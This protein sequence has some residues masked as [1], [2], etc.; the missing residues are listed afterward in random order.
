MLRKIE[1]PKQYLSSR[2]DGPY[3]FCA[4]S[5]LDAYNA[6]EWLFEYAK[7]AVETHG[8]SWHDFGDAQGILSSYVIKHEDDE[9]GEIQEQ[10]LQA[11]DIT[12][13]GVAIL[14]AAANGHEV[15]ELFAAWR[16]DLYDEANAP[17]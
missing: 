3:A 16:S 6:T 10:E 14:N 12:L 9:T 17:G 8:A 13:R 11:A 7:D 2:P 1:G 5:E 4:A 15:E